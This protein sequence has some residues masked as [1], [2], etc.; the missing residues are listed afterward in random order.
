MVYCAL[1]TL[2]GMLVCC[3]VVDATNSSMFA[4]FYN[5]KTVHKYVW[6]VGLN[7]QKHMHTKLFTNMDTLKRKYRK[8]IDEENN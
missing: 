7:K 5:A 6:F 2:Q 1:Q 3:N 8:Y 4:P